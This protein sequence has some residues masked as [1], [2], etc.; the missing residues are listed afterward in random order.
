MIKTF[1]QTFRYPFAHDKLRKT[2]RN[3]PEIWAQKTWPIRKGKSD[4]ETRHCAIS[5]HPRT[6]SCL[7]YVRAGNIP[8]D[9]GHF[10][11]RECMATR[12]DYRNVAGQC[13]KEDRFEGGKPYEF[14]IRD[15]REYSAKG[16]AA[17]LP[18]F[19]TLQS[20]GDGELEQFA[21]AARAF[22]PG[23]HDKL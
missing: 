18:N 23:L 22:L 2:R 20:S 16:T 12:L 17:K 15:R 13:K 8:V 10:R 5:T 7:Y 4:Q 14:G 9:A 11:R 1:S 19:Q 21:S 3:D 6:G